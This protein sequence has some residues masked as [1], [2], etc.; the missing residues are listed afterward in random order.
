MGSDCAD[1]GLISTF[2]RQQTLNALSIILANIYLVGY[3][4]GGFEDSP[5]AHDVHL[6]GYV[7]L[8]HC[9][10]S[11]IYHLHLV[12]RSYKEPLGFPRT[13]FTRLLDMGSLHLCCIAISLALSHGSALFCLVNLIVNTVFLMMMV[14]RYLRGA[15]E[16]PWAEH[17]EF[18]R[19][20]VCSAGY[21]LAILMRG[22]TASFLYSISLLALMGILMMVQPFGHAL[23][24]VPLA[25]FM[26]SLVESAAVP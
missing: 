8:L 19:T 18:L 21:V 9:P 17:L 24:R 20:G 2:R 6:I 26:R 11:A 7:A 25:L 10:C 5:F 4:F 12:L 14:L 3:S 15:H 16:D 1:S 13:S 23:S 22:H